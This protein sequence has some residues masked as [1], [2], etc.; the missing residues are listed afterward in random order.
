MA[1]HLHERG[2]GRD[3]WTQPG[4]YHLAK[5]GPL[6]SSARSVCHRPEVGGQVSIMNRHTGFPPEVRELI[7]ARAGGRCEICGYTASDMEA[8]DRRA[9]G[10][11][12]SLHRVADASSGGL[13]LCGECQRIAESY[14]SH[15]L[16]RG[17]LVRQSKS[18]LATPVLY[19]GAWVLL[20]DEGNT[21]RIPTPA[22]RAG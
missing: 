14:R 13:W 7:K 6:R 2:D 18:P 20:D 21:Y 1:T 15:A 22:G 12:G 5:F 19:R 16:D 8:H 17:W 9:R 10:V 4:E 3:I 11:M